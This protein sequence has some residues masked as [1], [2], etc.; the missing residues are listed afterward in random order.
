MK[1]ALF[2][3]LPWPE[4]TQP[5]ALFDATINEVILGEELGFH[6]AWLAEHHFTRYGLGSSPLV[7]AS[8]ILARTKK[9]R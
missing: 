2:T 1:F 7:V 6:S 4:D 3:H 8:H 5:K 9:S